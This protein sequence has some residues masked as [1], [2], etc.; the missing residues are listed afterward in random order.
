M[1]M[2]S[3]DKLINRRMRHWSRKI[4]QIYR[5]RCENRKQI[6]SI[7]LSISNSMKHKLNLKEFKL[8][9]MWLTERFTMYST[10]FLCNAIVVNKYRIDLS[11]NPCE[12]LP[13]FL[14]FLVAEIELLKQFG[15]LLLQIEIKFLATRAH[16]HKSL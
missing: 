10:C 5:W 15:T 1:E 12:L 14:F 3:I 4:W 16:K 11:L 8:Y 6:L 9:Q 2:S 13:F 7:G